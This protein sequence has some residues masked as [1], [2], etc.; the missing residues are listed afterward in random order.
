MDKYSSNIVSITLM[1]D[2]RWK[3]E[4]MD[5]NYKE[6]FIHNKKVVLEML[7]NNNK[8]GYS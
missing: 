1:D 3:M 5:F 4:K 2:G 7:T 8:K 6:F